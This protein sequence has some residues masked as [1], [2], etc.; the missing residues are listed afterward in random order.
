MRI[1]HK[2]QPDNDTAPEDI[3]ER[4]SSETNRVYLI[5]YIRQDKCRTLHTDVVTSGSWQ[6]FIMS[7][8]ICAVVC[9]CCG[10]N[11]VGMNSFYMMNSIVNLL[12]LTL[13]PRCK[14]SLTRMT[15]RVIPIENAPMRDLRRYRFVEQCNDKRC[16]MS[17][18]SIPR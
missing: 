15:Q 12:H 16:K 9:P 1:I 14:C 6:L 10:S 7:C 8:K 5:K 17:G 11:V 18:P 3:A 13:D 4:A 2:Q